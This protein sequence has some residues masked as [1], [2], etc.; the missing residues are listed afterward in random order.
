MLNTT[1]YRMMIPYFQGLGPKW[2]RRWLLN[3][4]PIHDIQRMK[5]LV[6]VM[7]EHT[8]RIFFGKRTALEAGDAAVKEQVAKGKDIM[9]ILRK[10][11]SR[12]RFDGGTDID[13]SCWF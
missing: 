8:Q 7:D 9:S 1:V 3:K 6:D 13:I 11:A 12:L 4:V 2:F 10:S 5:E